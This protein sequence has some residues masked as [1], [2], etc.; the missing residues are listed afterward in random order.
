MKSECICKIFNNGVNIPQKSHSTDVGF[1]IQC[2]SD[3]KFK[4]G[5]FTLEPFK[6]HL[7]HTGIFAEIDEKYGVIF[8]DRSGLAKNGLHILGGVIDP[9]YRGEWKVCMINLTNNTYVVKEGDRIAQA[10]IIPVINTTW[11]S[12]NEISKSDR[13]ESGYGSTG[14]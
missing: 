2:V 7:F 4:D 6:P 5:L 9:G 14:R 11:V 13:G 10:I 12:V 1:D 8:K 3:D